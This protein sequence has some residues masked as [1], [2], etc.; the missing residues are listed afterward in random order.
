M[1]VF[2]GLV[3]LIGSYLQ[4]WRGKPLA[5]VLV[6]IGGI[7]N[8][9]FVGVN[10]QFV[11]LYVQDKSGQLLVWADLIVVILTLGAAAINMIVSLM[12]TAETN[13]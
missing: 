11:F 3:V 4:A 13:K 5:F 8:L 7:C 9:I 2:P 6:F 10:A 12:F 1:L